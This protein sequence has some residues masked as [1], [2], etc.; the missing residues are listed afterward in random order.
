MQQSEQA[1]D[2]RRGGGEAVLNCG[3]Q[4]LSRFWYASGFKIEVSGYPMKKVILKNGKEL[5]IRK[6]A[7]EDTEQMAQFKTFISGESDFLSFGENEIE[8]TAKTERESIRSANAKDNSVII[9]ALIDEEVAGFVTFNGG[10]KIRKRHAG[11]MGISVRKKYWGLGIASLLLE[12]LIEWAK[13][14][15]MIRKIDLLTRA[16]NEK[17]IKLYEKY[18]FKRE[19]ILTRDLCI[20]GVFYDSFSMGLS[21]DEC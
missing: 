10:V 12:I 8:I 6:A 9:I 11:E 7:E 3:I 16:D 17:A 4:R 19:G 20:N 14:T 2:R 21:I 13:G 5:L 1:E 18:G 15:Q